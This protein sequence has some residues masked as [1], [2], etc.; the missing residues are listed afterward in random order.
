M[1]LNM[2]KCAFGVQSS[3]FLGFMVSE[4]GIEA[5]PKKAQAIIG[6]EP[7]RHLNKVQRLVG[8]IATLNRFVL[9]ST[10]KYLPF[11]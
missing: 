8:R 4:S 11:F 10:D 5:N 9:R 3:K 1:K 2:T 7:L 6:M